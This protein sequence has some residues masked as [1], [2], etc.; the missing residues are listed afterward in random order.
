MGQGISSE[1][2]AAHIARQSELAAQLQDI[3]ERQSRTIE[4]AAN[5]HADVTASLYGGGGGAGGASGGGGGSVSVSASAHR[6]GVG[7]SVAGGNAS[8]SGL[9]GHVSVGS[10]AG[11]GSSTSGGVGASA[12]LSGPSRQNPISIS[13]SAALASLRDETEVLP[14]DARACENAKREAPISQEEVEAPNIVWA[15][16][17]PEEEQAM[18]STKPWLAAM[19]PPTNFVFGRH[20]PK[21]QDGGGLMADDTATAA[22]NN[23]DDEPTTHAD[24]P[25]PK[26]LELER[27]C[28]YTAANTR[29]GAQWADATT[30]VYHVGSV[31]ISLNVESGKQTFFTAH[32]EDICALAV[33]TC[34][35][36]PAAGGHAAHRLSLV[37]AAAASD[38]AADPSAA[39]NASSSAAAPRPIVAT[40][41]SGRYPAIY[42]WDAR[43]GAQL[44]KIAGRHRRAI[45]AMCFGAD[46][47][48]IAS[49]GIDD[50]NTVLIFEWA[51]GAVLG[52]AAAATRV[53]DITP[54]FTIG[55]NP[56]RDFVT[57]GDAQVVFWTSA[58]TVATGGGAAVAA[59]AAAPVSVGRTK[60]M[61]PAA[62]AIAAAAA[63]AA[64]AT[65]AAAAANEGG[66]G[67]SA[68]GADV[69]RAKAEEAVSSAASD[70]QLIDMA[71][72]FGHMGSAAQSFLCIRTTRTHTLVGCADGHVYAFR[73]D[74]LVAALP[75]HQG[76]VHSLQV[77]PLDGSANVLGID[78][79][80]MRRR[81]LGGGGG[82]ASASSPATPTSGVGAGGSGVGGRAFTPASP[83][84]AS[85][86]AT[87]VPPEIRLLTGG[88]DGVVNCWDIDTRRLEFSLNMN[89]TA[90][91]GA[92]SLAANPLRYG[93]NAVR[94]LSVYVG[95]QP[96]IA[97]SVAASGGT[98]ELLKTLRK[99]QQ[100][101]Q[102]AAAEAANENAAVGISA[103]VRASLLSARS[104]LLVGTI[105]GILSVA[106]S[107][108]D[109][110][111][112]APRSATWP[113]S[114][115]TPVTVGH[116]AD[117]ASLGGIEGEL[118]GLAVSPVPGSAR[119]A[120]CGEDGVLRVWDGGF[121]SSTTSPSTAAAAM[122][123]AAV[124]PRPAQCVAFA[125]DGA[126]IA[127]GYLNGAI[128]VF[129]VHEKR[130]QLVDSGSNKDCGV[131]PAFSE[132]I[133]LR[134]LIEMRR[135]ARR[136][137][138]LQYSPCRTWLAA[139]TADG[140]VDLY[141]IAAN[142]FGAEFA[143]GDS[144]T[145]SNDA[146]N[147]PFAPSAGSQLTYSLSLRLA[148]ANNSVCMRFDFSKPPPPRNANPFATDSS[149]PSVALQQSPSRY[150]QV[151]SQSYELLFYDLEEAGSKRT[152]G[153]QCPQIL[154]MSNAEARSKMRDVEWASESSFLGWS[155]QGVWLSG[156]ADGSDVNALKRS[157][158]CS[159]I[160]TACESG[161]VRLYNYPCVGSGLD[162]GG[163]LARR[164]FSRAVAGH[165]RRVAEVGWS[166]D[167]SRVFSIG[168]A[169]RCCMQWRVVDAPAQ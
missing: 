72:R 51:T 11:G 86:F 165:A 25:P 84:A 76:P 64:K 60:S 113:F 10:G 124:L 111:P 142:P 161:H 127:V 75:A 92:A 116:S 78:Y 158:N 73:D 105:D 68:D 45:G 159:L 138:C 35:A 129:T 65:K 54:N 107:N 139:G 149:S 81:V 133:A 132:T 115:L 156:S 96:S 85:S 49:V 79:A 153:K 43:T 143:V 24:A 34:P 112:S 106:S 94:T 141:E 37:A 70:V 152:A 164:P 40:A 2:I 57:A 82:A 15:E 32:S 144:A 55:F 39:K 136:I 8:V 104:R 22:A 103:A 148:N 121:S 125:R 90:T 169:D 118:L 83:A 12:L 101:Q 52:E 163:R 140:N 160:A 134:P 58:A 9:V 119:F 137:Q 166:A 128:G 3:V 155:V 108:G 120:T 38:S 36:A 17:T 18:A 151:C 16:P 80:A 30:V 28:G 167:D 87:A 29:N 114:A 126:S 168:A 31:G 23:V 93:T 77:V 88:R 135:C 46:G 67:G 19:A 122:I 13:G 162:R 6:S 21:P 59:V 145:A 44:A 102:Q 157:H 110:A 131:R 150:V 109:D 50:A 1:Q 63:S 66:F 56:N 98:I 91:A 14:S 146:E 20:R 33:H 69:R 7:G 97:A 74:R 130:N 48:T 123:G 117:L 154:P 71:A 47:T 26:T 95:P 53:F 5:K 100:Q 99:A 4:V 89:T 41:E 42:V 147:D 62:A 27:V 61:S